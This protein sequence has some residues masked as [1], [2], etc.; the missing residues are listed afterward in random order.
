MRIKSVRTRTIEAARN[1]TSENG[2]ENLVQKYTG[3]NED[4][5]GVGVGLNPIN[6]KKI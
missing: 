4:T 2:Y 6:I 1:T 5:F 3:A